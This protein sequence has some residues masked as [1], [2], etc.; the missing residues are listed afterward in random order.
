MV[1]S[2]SY[3]VENDED[4]ARQIRKAQKQVGDLRFAMAE[5]ARDWFKSNRTI[6]ALKGSGLFPPLSPAYKRTKENRAGQNL[7]I[8]VGA[9]KGGGESGM[10]RDSVTR[11]TDRNAIVKIGKASVVI[12]TKVRHG[13]FHQSD[14]PRKTLLPQRKFLFIGAEAPRSAGSRITGR[15]ERFKAIIANEVQSQLDSL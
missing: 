2:T 14:E 5:I 1:I 11:M 15:S 13:I 10:L 7:P 6:F 12:G 8:L 4:L 9:K 3:E